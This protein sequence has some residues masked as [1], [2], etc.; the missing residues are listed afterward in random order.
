MLVALQLVTG[1]REPKRQ[2]GLAGTCCAN[3]KKSPMPALQAGG[4]QQRGLRPIFHRASEQVH[5]KIFDHRSRTEDLLDDHSS[6]DDAEMAS[7]WLDR[8]GDFARRRAADL[9]V[10]VE[11]PNRF[12]H[13][14]IRR[15]Q[16]ESTVER[17][18]DYFESDWINPS[19]TSESM[20]ARISS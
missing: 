18:R 5:V 7:Q 14:A 13:A 11:K 15:L 10:A 8:N 17:A 1:T 12:E 9:R 16:N 4:M 19:L 6:L 20:H 2:R 3:E